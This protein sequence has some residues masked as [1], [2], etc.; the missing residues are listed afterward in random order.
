MNS[1]EAVYSRVHAKPQ[2]EQSQGLFQ[3]SSGRASHRPSMLAVRHWCRFLR[4]LPGL[5]SSGLACKAASRRGTG[6]VEASLVG[7][8]AIAWET[9]CQNQLCC[10]W[11]R[12]SLPAVLEAVLR[13]KHEARKKDGEGRESG[14]RMR[15]K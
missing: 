12:G 2:L 15:E 1:L 10:V 4:T 11:F 6:I 13:F 8:Q 3:P 7:R 14:C 9:Q 5:S